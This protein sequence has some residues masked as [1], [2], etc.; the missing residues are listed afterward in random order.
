VGRS[1]ALNHLRVK[2]VEP[3]K[4]VLKYFAQLYFYNLNGTGCEVMYN[5]NLD[6]TVE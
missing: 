2:G 4:Q 1:P 5:G 6:M 3:P